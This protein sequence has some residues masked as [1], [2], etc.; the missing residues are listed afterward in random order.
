RTQRAIL[1]VLRV[2]S[3]FSMYSGVANL[4]ILWA[5]LQRSE[6]TYEFQKPVGDGE[7]VYDG[8]SCGERLYAYLVNVAKQCARQTRRNVLGYCRVS[9][10]SGKQAA[11]E[12]SDPV[13]REHS[14]SI[15]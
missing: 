12:S 9:Q 13:T 10:D 15:I 11:C 14:Q 8:D 4:Q 2:D 5:L 3:Y 1:R 7:D 6:A